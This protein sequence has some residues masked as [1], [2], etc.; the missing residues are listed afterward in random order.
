MDSAWILKYK[1][2]NLWAKHPWRTLEK[3]LINEASNS[4]ARQAF[5]NVLIDIVEQQTERR[6][7]RGVTRLSKLKLEGKERSMLNWMRHF[8]TLRA[9][10]AYVESWIFKLNLALDC[11]HTALWAW[12]WASDD[13]QL[14]VMEAGEMCVGKKLFSQFRL[15]SY[16]DQ[17]T[18]HINVTWFSLLIYAVLAI[19]SYSLKKYDSLNKEFIQINTKGSKAG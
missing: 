13:W 14:R 19:Y 9:E 3:S 4:I 17:L 10:K 15:F 7:S 11:S 5:L 16:S 2:Y 6:E 12:P 8:S 1:L 18:T